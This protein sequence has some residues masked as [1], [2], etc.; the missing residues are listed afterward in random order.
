MA[1]VGPAEISSASV[2]AAT[3]TPSANLHELKLTLEAGNYS[4]FSEVMQAARESGRTLLDQSFAA[5]PSAET[6]VVH[7]LAEGSGTIVPLGL[8]RVSREDWR[9]QPDIDLWSQWFGG[10]AQALLGF[11][12]TL[13]AQ[14]AGE[15]ATVASGSDRT[16][17]GRSSRMRHVLTQAN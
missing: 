13:T 7:L 2:T 9:S 11:G 5:S 15:D 4:T 6:V 3:P 10:S 12:P 1:F 17:R 8:V 14:S 16:L